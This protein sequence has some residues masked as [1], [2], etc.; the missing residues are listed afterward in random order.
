MSFSVDKAMHHKDTK[1][2][3]LLVAEAGLP[4]SVRPQGDPIDAWLD[5]METVE[6]LCPQLPMPEMRVGTDFRL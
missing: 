5:L 2:T 3:P 6:A 1:Q 4:Y